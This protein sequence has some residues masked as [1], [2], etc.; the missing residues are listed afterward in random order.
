MVKSTGIYFLKLVAASYFGL[1]IEVLT[2]T[3]L[4]LSGNQTL[5]G[6]VSCILGILAAVG[7]FFFLCQRE[8]YHDNGGMGKPPF[9]R[10]VISTCI[11]VSLYVLITVIVRYRHPAAAVFATG[12]AH[13]MAGVG[14]DTD[15]TVMAAEHGGWMF[16]SFLICTLPLI[17]AMIF[18]YRYG[19]KRRQRDREELTGE[20]TGK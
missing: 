13:P 20:K 4:R 6:V 17:P 5:A 2:V 12:F 16:L 10:A 18:G 3:P 14:S 11:A 1:L 8:G 15:L 7:L 19:C 9:K